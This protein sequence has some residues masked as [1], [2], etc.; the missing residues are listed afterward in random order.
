MHEVIFRSRLPLIGIGLAYH[1]GFCADDKFKGLAAW[2]IIMINEFQN[3]PLYLLRDDNFN[4]VRLE[5][6]FP[7]ALYLSTVQFCILEI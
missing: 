3:L 7:T 4:P 5:I 6:N 1:Y 2:K